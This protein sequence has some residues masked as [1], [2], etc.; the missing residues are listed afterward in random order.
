VSMVLATAVVPAVL[1][2]EERNPFQGK[3]R[4]AVATLQI[5]ENPDKT[6]LKETSFLG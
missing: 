6:V 3:L 4:W 5:L 2:R 1:A